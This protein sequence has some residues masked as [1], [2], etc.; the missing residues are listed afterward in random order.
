L[1]T[2]YSTSI[3]QSLKERKEGHEHAGARYAGVQRQQDA[4]VASGT[5][6]VPEKTREILV[7]DLLSP[8]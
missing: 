8:A 7:A 5:L 4:A 6:A 3:P 2:H 1:D